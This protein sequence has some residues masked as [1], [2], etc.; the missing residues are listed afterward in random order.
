MH[1]PR[2]GW[3]LVGFASLAIVVL[4]HCAA[5][6]APNSLILNEANMVS[7]TKFLDQGNVDT[8]FGRVQG[9]GQ[10]WLEF[11]V[12]QGDPKAG[13]GYSNTLDLR[14]WTINWSYDKDNLHQSVG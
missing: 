11:L 9:N 8:A 6:F 2:F 1:R 12:V 10:N 3:F 13:G 4:P 5:A 14:G 7:G